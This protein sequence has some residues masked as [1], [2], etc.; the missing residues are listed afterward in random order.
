MLTWGGRVCFDGG[1]ERVLNRKMRKDASTLKEYH[2]QEHV[3]L[4]IF[5]SDKVRREL[6]M[7]S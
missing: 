3:A 7:G 2:A 4:K 6:F 5:C 1:I